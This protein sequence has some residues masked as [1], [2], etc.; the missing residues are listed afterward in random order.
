MTAPHSQS[1]LLLAGALFTAGLF[2]QDPEPTEPYRFYGG[3]VDRSAKDAAVEACEYRVLVEERR[4][5]E[6]LNKT[7]CIARVHE[8]CLAD[9]DGDGEDSDREPVGRSGT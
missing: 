1:A 9:P 2:A 3:D 6:T 5:N 7:A 4:C 8:Q